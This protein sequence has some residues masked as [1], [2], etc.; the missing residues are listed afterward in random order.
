[1]WAVLAPTPLIQP[2]TAVATNSGPLSERMWAGV[3]RAMNRSANTS[4]T[5][6]EPSLRA[7][8]IARHSRVN[9][10]T[11]F[12]MPILR[13]SRVRSSTKSYAQTWLG[14]SG[15]SRTQEPSFSHNRPRFGWRAGTFNPSRRQIRST[16]LRLTRQPSARSKAVT[17]R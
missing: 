16:R 3:P 11:T 13:P 14:L 6:A 17:R 2:F 7:T 10:S 5:S 15:R 1:M 4:V 8:R 12:S 9:P